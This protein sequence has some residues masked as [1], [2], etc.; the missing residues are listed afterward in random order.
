MSFAY[1]I[2]T[3]IK[4]YYLVTYSHCTFSDI[5]SPSLKPELNPAN[6]PRLK[7]VIDNLL[8]D[9]ETDEEGIRFFIQSMRELKKTGFELEPTAFLTSKKGL[10]I[11]IKALEL[12]IDDD[13]Q[14]HQ[15]FSSLNEALVWLDE[16][17]NAQA[18]YRIRDELLEEVRSL[19]K[20]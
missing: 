7:F 13:V 12:L 18:I 10:A 4:I 11:F 17:E 3:E 1:R 16:I 8:G 5:F 14:I 20:R 2:D 19:H 9:L 15:A 6:R